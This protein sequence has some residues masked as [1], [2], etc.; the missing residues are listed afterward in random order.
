MLD[1]FNKEQVLFQTISQEGKKNKHLKLSGIEQS[2][3]IYTG[4]VILQ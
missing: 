3:V 1:A 4:V 2:L